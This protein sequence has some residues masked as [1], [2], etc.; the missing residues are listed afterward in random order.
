MPRVEKTNKDEARSG[1]VWL[2]LYKVQDI[3]VHI[4]VCVYN[5]CIYIY[6]L[7]NIYNIIYIY[8]HT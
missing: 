7:Y 4:Y 1:F 6:I 5:I 8:T 3:H 2:R